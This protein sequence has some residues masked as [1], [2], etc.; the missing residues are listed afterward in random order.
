MENAMPTPAEMFKMSRLV[1][2]IRNKGS[3]DRIDLVI[4]S[5]ISNSYYEKLKPYILRLFK[6]IEYDRATRTWRTIKRDESITG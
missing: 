5:G 4:E 1:G 3:I 6:D 2:I